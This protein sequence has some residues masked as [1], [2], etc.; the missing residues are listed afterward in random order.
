MHAHKFRHPAEVEEEHWKERLVAFTF[1][2]LAQFFFWYYGRKVKKYL[3]EVCP[4]NRMSF[5]G[6][7][8]RNLINFKETSRYVKST[9]LYVMFDGIVIMVFVNYE[10]SPSNRAFIYHVTRLGFF[11]IYLHII[12]PSCIQIPTEPVETTVPRITKF[13][14]RKPAVLEPRRPTDLWTS[15]SKEVYKG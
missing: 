8:K 14:V 10:I 11:H 9:F 12:L 7:Y 4:G 15:T 1:P 6:K 2:S 13:Y 5:I 3:K